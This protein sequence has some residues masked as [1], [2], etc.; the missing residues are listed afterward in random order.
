M[1]AT[2][3]A[4]R[5]RGFESTYSLSAMERA[6]INASFCS[7]TVIVVGCGDNRR[8]HTIARPDLSCL[9][10]A[11]ASDN[12]DQAFSEIYPDENNFLD[13]DIGPSPD[14][15]SRVRNSALPFAASVSLTS[16]SHMAL[17]A[18]E[19][20]NLPVLHHPLPGGSTALLN[21]RARDQGEGT[22]GTTL[23]LGAQVLSAFL[24][25]HGTTSMDRD[26]K[27]RALELGAG[28]GLLSLTLA[29]MGYDV[30]SSDIDP[31]VGILASNLSANW[32]IGSVSVTK[33]DWLDPPL[34]AGEF[35][36]IVTAD[37]IYTPDL[38]GP[39]WN[40]VAK[41]SSPTT[42]S[43]VAVENRDPRLMESAYERGKE[44]GFDVKRINANRIVKAVERVWGW[45]KGDGWEGVEI[46][47]AKFRGKKES[48]VDSSA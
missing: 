39:L 37:T 30:L 48:S 29:E 24:A 4:S 15:H 13:R 2:R 20:K 45:K 34:L 7:V 10:W 19:T 9:R 11:Q 25:K 36:V 33:I 1:D 31:V 17:P 16:L 35:D 3:K 46:W 42:V 27:L 41:Y 14:I 40:T 8:V 21:Q 12:A 47:K 43:Y 32:A 22:T 44:L 26:P 28:V 38:V 18:P 6:S 5:E 23:W